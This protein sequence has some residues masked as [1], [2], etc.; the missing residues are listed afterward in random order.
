[1][2]GAKPVRTT[3]SALVLFV[4]SGVVWTDKARTTTSART[5]AIATSIAF[6]LVNS[7]VLSASALSPA[8]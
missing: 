4:I 6:A 2:Y 5:T 8:I 3:P 1:L 7:T